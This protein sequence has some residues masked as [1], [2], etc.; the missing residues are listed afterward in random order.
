MRQGDSDLSLEK[1]RG[2]AQAYLDANISGAQV[3]GEGMA[4]YGYYTFD[5]EVDGLIA[6]MLS[7]NGFSGDAWVHTWHGQFISEKE[8]E[9]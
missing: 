7:I 9:E 1:A 3:E 6:G 5:Y 4:F 2:L 8:F